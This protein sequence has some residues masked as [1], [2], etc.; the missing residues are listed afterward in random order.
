LRGVRYCSVRA[1]SDWRL[2]ASV[3]GPG[4]GQSFPAPEASRRVTTF[5][6]ASSV[7]AAGSG[8]AAATGGCRI[9]LTSAPALQTSPGREWPESPMD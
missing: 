9:I 1:P 6:T 3:G 7:S 4:G 2:I 5:G 8:W